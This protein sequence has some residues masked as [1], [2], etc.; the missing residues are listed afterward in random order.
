M[1]QSNAMFGHNIYTIRTAKVNKPYA[2]P[3]I[4]LYNI[5]FVVVIVVVA[6][7]LYVGYC[8]FFFFLFFF[9]LRF[10]SCDSFAWYLYLRLR[11]CLYLHPYQWPFVFFFLSRIMLYYIVDALNTRV[12]AYCFI[13]PVLLLL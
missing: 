5:S 9:S 13:V 4:R 12:H 8:F 10:Y 7:T 11:R 6:V 3:M 1:K 2:L